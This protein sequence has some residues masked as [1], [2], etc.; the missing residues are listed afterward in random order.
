MTLLAGAIVAGA[1]GTAATRRDTNDPALRRL[2]GVDAQ[3][4]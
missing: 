4:R 2:L 3:R 1:H